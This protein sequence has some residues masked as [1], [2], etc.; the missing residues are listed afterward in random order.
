MNAYAYHNPVI[1]IIQKERKIV[2]VQETEKETQ[3]FMV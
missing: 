2:K 3:T 1:I